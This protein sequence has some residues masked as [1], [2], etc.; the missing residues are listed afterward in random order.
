MTLFV[1]FL[2]LLLVISVRAFVESGVFCQ[3]FSVCAY[4]ESQKNVVVDVILTDVLD[5]CVFKNKHCK[6]MSTQVL[7]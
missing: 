6:I 5:T 7:H 2:V 4:L 3:F 1:L